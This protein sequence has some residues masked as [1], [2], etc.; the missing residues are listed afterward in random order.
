M[1]KEIKNSG[2][3][4]LKNKYK[5]LNHYIANKNYYEEKLKDWVLS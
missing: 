5:E 3:E 4:I 1:I 2:I